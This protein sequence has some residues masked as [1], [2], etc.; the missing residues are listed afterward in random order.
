LLFARFA[1]IIPV[2]ERLVARPRLGVDMK[3]SFKAL[4]AV[5]LA[6]AFVLPSIADAQTA[7][8][9]ARHPAAG[10]RDITVHATES[11]LTAGT[12]ATVGQ[13]SNYAL[14][15]FSSPTTFNPN[16]DHT[17]VGVRGLDRMPNNLTVP[18]CC[19]P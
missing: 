4:A 10:G 15:T 1:L 2:A 3:R 7:H 5:A 9:H 17:T 6:A 8:R 12:G 13:F 19:V 16:I 11:W 18:N 14:D